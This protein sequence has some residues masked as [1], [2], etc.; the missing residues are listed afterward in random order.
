MKFTE[1]YSDNPSTNLD[2]SIRVESPGPYLKQSTSVSGDIHHY[3]HYYNETPSSS[4]CNTNNIS[5]DL[6]QKVS[7][8]LN[9]ILMQ[10]KSLHE[11]TDP[12][13]SKIDSLEEVIGELLK[14]KDNGT[15][16][17][18]IGKNPPHDSNAYEAIRGVIIDGLGLYDMS[19]SI[20][21]AEFVKGGI[22]FELKTSIDKHRILIRAQERFNTDKRKIV[23]Y[24]L[25]EE[26]EPNSDVPEIF[27]RTGS[28]TSNTEKSLE[29]SDSD[30]VERFLFE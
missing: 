20:K 1:L 24:S 13:R 2:E 28:N 25:N 14:E 12:L 19:S 10:L 26:N 18:L 22:L 9:V 23:E 4:Q 8:Q 21:F 30:I 7:N 17:L 27:Y 6:F 15:K 29:E 5:N 11:K 16:L 3:H